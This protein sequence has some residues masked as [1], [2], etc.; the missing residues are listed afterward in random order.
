MIERNCKNCVSRICIGKGYPMENVCADHKF[1]HEK[2][3]EEINRKY[4]LED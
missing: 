2:M 4:R 1:E 3:I